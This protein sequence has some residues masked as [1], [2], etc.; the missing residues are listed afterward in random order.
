VSLSGETNSAIS[1]GRKART[2]L[3]IIQRHETYTDKGQYAV[4]T[5]IAVVDHAELASAGSHLRRE[6]DGVVFSMSVL[7]EGKE[8]HHDRSC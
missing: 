2:T 4:M 6:E 3:Q 8:S 5:R 7:T 1:Q